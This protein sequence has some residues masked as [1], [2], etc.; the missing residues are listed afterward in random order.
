MPSFPVRTAHTGWPTTQLVA[1]WRSREDGSRQPVA[2]L[3]PLHGERLDDYQRLDL[4]ASREWQKGGWRWRL[5]AGVDNLLD[6]P[7]QR[8]FEPVPD[9][10]VDGDELDVI[11]P[12]ELGRGRSP[13]VALS[14]EF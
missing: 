11:L 4:A 7:N 2:V 1:E 5:L 3:G 9:F 14:V 12:P 10:L 13:R 6:R 8:G